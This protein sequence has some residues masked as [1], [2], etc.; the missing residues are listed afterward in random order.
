MDNERDERGNPICPVC[1]TA[2]K[3]GESVMRD[4]NHV[5]HVRCIDAHGERRASER[6]SERGA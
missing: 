2:I 5:V 4:G 3:P 1:K 6:A